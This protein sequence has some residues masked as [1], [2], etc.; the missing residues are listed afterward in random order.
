MKILDAFNLFLF[1]P[2]VIEINTKKLIAFG[3]PEELAKK[4][5]DYYS[6]FASGDRLNA[7]TYTTGLI[8]AKGVASKEDYAQLIDKIYSLP[9]FKRDVFN[10]SGYPSAVFFNDLSN[11]IDLHK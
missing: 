10:D 8:A 2:N 7:A 11:H 5:I 9:P 4:I 6:I 3:V 1:G